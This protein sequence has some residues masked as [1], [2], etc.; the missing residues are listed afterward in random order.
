MQPL[1]G[2]CSLWMTCTP[3]CGER[4]AALLLRGG[5]GL[6]EPGEAVASATMSAPVTATNDPP[7][8][9]PGSFIVA[10]VDGARPRLQLGTFNATDPDSNAQIR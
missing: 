9:R 2:A 8:F 3:R 7:A 10:E 1:A 6:Q 5:E 4:G